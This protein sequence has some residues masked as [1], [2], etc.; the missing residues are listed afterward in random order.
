[1]P[2]QHS[3]SGMFHT[4]YPDAAASGEP[5]RV[6]DAATGAGISRLGTVTLPPGV[7]S[8]CRSPEWWCCPQISTIGIDECG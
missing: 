6:F 3:V 8:A 4:V 2:L 5:P 7:L 1:M